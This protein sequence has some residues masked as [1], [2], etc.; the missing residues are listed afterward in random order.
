ALHRRWR[1]RLWR[2]DG[3]EHSKTALPRPIR[4]E[5]T[6]VFEISDHRNRADT[7]IPP[8]SCRTLWGLEEPAL[9]PEAPVLSRAADF[10]LFAPLTIRNDKFISISVSLSSSLYETSLHSTH[11]RGHAEH[12]HTANCA[13]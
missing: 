1:I 3:R 8:L 11:G 10:S 2:G 4:V 13:I 7:L 9:S 12:V 5:G 6:H